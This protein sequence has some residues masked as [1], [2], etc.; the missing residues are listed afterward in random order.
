MC[1]VLSAGLLFGV[2]GLLTGLEDFG[3]FAAQEDF[4]Q[5]D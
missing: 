2:L 4:G 1:F 5:V 3:D